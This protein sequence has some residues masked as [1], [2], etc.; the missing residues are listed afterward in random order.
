MTDLTVADPAPPGA[1]TAQARSLAGGP[2]LGALR[3]ELEQQRSF[4]VW[5][6]EELAATTR[7]G[8]AAS[9]DEAVHRVAL[10][11]TEAATTV[12][13][14]IDAA[15]DRM[16]R[17]R[18]GRCRRCGVGIAPERLH[19]LPMASLCMACQS[20]EELEGRGP[21]ATSESEGPR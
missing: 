6:L 2:D 3:T 5:Q 10:A 4:R 19:V 7:R 16:A 13:G 12:L 21:Q 20:A 18:Y 11:L 17:G 9:R 8:S 1:E 15:L 14:E